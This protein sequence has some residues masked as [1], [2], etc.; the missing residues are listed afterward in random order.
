[1]GVEIGSIAGS[2][3]FGERLGMG[4]SLSAI[5]G[6]YCFCA[7]GGMGVYVG[8]SRSSVRGGV[9]IVVSLGVDVDFGVE[10]RSPVEWI[11]SSC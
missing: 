2:K 10:G 5:L 1:M 7:E 9:G 4:V 11:D 8:I 3:E 6:V